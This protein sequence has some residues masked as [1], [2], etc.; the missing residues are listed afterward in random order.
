MPLVPRAVR[1]APPVRV[2]DT[3]PPVDPT[4]HRVVAPEAIAE[5]AAEKR[6]PEPVQKPPEDTAPF[7]A[8]DEDGLQDNDAAPEHIETKDEWDFAA[9]RAKERALALSARVAP[10]AEHLAAATALR[11][12]MTKPEQDEDARALARDRFLCDTLHLFRIC[13]RPAC[14]RTQRC[15]DN[16]QLCLLIGSD[17]VPGEAREWALRLIEAGETGESL[18]ELEAAFPDEQLAYRCWIAGLGARLTRNMNR[19]RRRAPP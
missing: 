18:D 7:R 12:A 13:P 8:A 17:A 16:P 1:P 3:W 2:D 11:D 9:A 4:R 6:V 10:T 15:R 14:Q 19:P 5:V